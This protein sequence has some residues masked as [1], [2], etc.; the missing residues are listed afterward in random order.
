MN[1][2]Y[3]PGEPI[4]Y[5]SY[6]VPN[7]NVHN[8]ISRTVYLPGAGIGRDA[9][10]GGSIR[11]GLSSGVNSFNFLQVTADMRPCDGG[12]EETV[13]VPCYWGVQPVITNLTLETTVSGLQTTSSTMIEGQ[14][15]LVINVRLSAAPT[16]TVTLGFSHNFGI[17]AQDISWSNGNTLDANNFNSGRD[18]VITLFDDNQLEPQEIKQITFTGSGANMSI[19]GVTMNITIIDNDGLEPPIEP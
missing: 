3:A 14:L 1:P 12:E 6:L 7:V 9:R 2:I 11:T 19:T 10:L 8:P 5:D 16:G 18:V 15:P 13:Y 17:D 4:Q